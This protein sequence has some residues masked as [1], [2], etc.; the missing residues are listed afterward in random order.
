[1]LPTAR[2]SEAR[3]M[4]GMNAFTQQ[5]GLAQRR[6]EA[7]NRWFQHFDDHQLRRDCP[8]SYHEQLLRQA[9]EMDRLH[10]IEWQEWRDLRRLADWAF[11]K[12]VAGLD[13]HAFHTPVV[14]AYGRVTAPAPHSGTP[15]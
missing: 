7:I 5:T 9:D 1:M 13:Y 2:L 6:L 3:G 10:L 8:S 12:A 15:G 14:H 11:L 4:T